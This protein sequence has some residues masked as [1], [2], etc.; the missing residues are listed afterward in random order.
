M[1]RLLLALATLFWASVAQAAPYAA[2]V[3]AADTGETLYADNAE[4]P[5]HPASITKMMTL[6]LAFEALQDGKLRLADPVVWSRHAAS[7]QPSKIGLRPGQFLSV[8]ETIRAIAVHSGNDAAVALAERID[9]TEAAFAAHMTRQARE[10]G[11]TRTHFVN[12]SGLSN[13]AHVTTAHDI[14]ILSLALMK[15]FPGY[16]RYFS[17][18]TFTYGTRRYSNHNHLLGRDGVDGIKT[19]YTADA[20][21]TLAASAQRDG[22]RLI[23]VVLGAR[24]SR[25]RNADVARLLDLGFTQ[26][27]ENRRGGSFSIAANFRPQ[28]AGGAPAMPAATATGDDDEPAPPV[29]AR[30]RPAPA[31]KAAA[32]HKATTAGKASKKA[33]AKATAKKATSKTKAKSTATA[34]KA[35]SAKHS[36]AKAKAKSATAAKAKTTAKTKTAASTKAKAAK[37]KKAASAPTGKSSVKHKKKDADKGR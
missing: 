13:R 20:G 4:T 30:P 16:Y 17:T 11:M 29:R 33:P 32:P 10:L 27:A 25:D 7:Q 35:S 34:K 2:F 31:K 23:A 14:A 15:R 28:G 21:F 8:D 9:K 1:A 6:Y 22:R 26:L 12:A 3:M 24:T 37:P 18:P 19:G 36:P 5:L